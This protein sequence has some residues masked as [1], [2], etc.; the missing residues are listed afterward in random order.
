M[1]PT[2]RFAACGISQSSTP[3]R[4]TAL[5]GRY[6]IAQVGDS[7]PRRVGGLGYR[8]IHERKPCRGDINPLATSTRLFPAPSQRSS[9]R[10]SQFSPF[11]ATA[12]PST[13]DFSI[14]KHLQPCPELV[15]PVS[16][17]PREADGQHEV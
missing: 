3:A 2:T 10:L 1:P 6:P 4:L 14:G 5:K 15:S 7:P 12:A 8:S 11:D 16:N 9:W 17:R 13:G